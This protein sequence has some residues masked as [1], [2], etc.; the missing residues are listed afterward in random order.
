MT[1]KDLKLG[2]SQLPLASAPDSALHSQRFK[3][4]TF[5]PPFPAPLYLK[6]HLPSHGAW[7]ELIK[8]TPST[9][10]V[11][12]AFLQ[13]LLDLPWEEDVITSHAN[14]KIRG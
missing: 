13:P 11:Y 6:Y 7:H 8:V 12:K 9:F 5:L 2:S 10:L 4:Q 1:T 14:K 3:N